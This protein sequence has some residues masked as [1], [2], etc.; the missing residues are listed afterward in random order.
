[1]VA[2]AFQVIRLTDNGDNPPQF[3]IKIESIPQNPTEFTQTLMP[4]VPKS[5][6]LLSTVYIDKEVCLRKESYANDLRPY[7]F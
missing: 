5:M 2:G 6:R 7:Q 4:C 3:K 1:M